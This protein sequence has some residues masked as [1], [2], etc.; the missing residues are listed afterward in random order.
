VRYLGP[1]LAWCQ[2][3]CS[4]AGLGNDAVLAV[5]KVVCSPHSSKTYLDH[6]KLIC[7]V[8]YTLVI[9]VRPP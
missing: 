7:C 6:I 1:G 5:R 4:R 3:H 9:E 8:M 2:R